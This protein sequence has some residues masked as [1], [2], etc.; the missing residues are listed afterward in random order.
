M[1]GVRRKLGIMLIL[2]GVAVPLAFVSVA[3]ACGILATLHL[4]RNAVSSGALVSGTGGNYNT[5]PKASVVVLRFNSRTGG[6]LWTGRPNANGTIFP[7]FTAPTVP[8]GYYLVDATQTSA[9]GASVAG[10]PGRAVLRIGN[11]S[12]TKHAVAA[13]WPSAA[14]GPSAGSHATSGSTPGGLANGGEILVALL[15]ASLLAGG[16]LV[17]RDDRRRGRRSAPAV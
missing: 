2:A 8:A 4:N 3:Y 1:A 15:S 16:V 5:S 11:P 9:T 17:L 12:R 7:T 6:V 14:S 13:L 10:T